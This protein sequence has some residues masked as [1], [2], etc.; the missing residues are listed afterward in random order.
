MHNLKNLF[1]VL[2]ILLLG[3]SSCSKDDDSTPITSVASLEGKW[4]LTKEGGIIN[5]Q[6]VLTDYQHT[7]GC[8]KDYMEF[9]SG[10]ITKEHYFKNPNCQETIDT[11]TWNKTNNSVVITFTNVPT[12]T[13]VNF[14]ILELTSTT[15]KMKFVRSGITYLSVFTRIQ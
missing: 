15:L 9:L 5:N 4:Q 7:S 1:L 11:G 14:E 2:S 13:N 10:N 8:A 3:L 12:P 6:E